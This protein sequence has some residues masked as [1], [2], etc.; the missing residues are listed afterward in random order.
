MEDEQKASTN[1]YIALDIHRVGL[2][3]VLFCGGRGEP[4][5][6]G[7]PA[8]MPGGAPEPGGLAGEAPA[9]QRPGGDRI[10]DQRLA[11]V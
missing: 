8:A 3:Q 10:D 7:D 2:R 4:G 5:R 9:A 1:R 6:G 11:R